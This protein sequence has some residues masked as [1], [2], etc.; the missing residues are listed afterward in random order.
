MFP[1]MEGTPVILVSEDQEKSLP[2]GITDQFH[3]VVVNSAEELGAVLQGGFDGW[4]A[5]RDRVLR[6]SER[7]G[8]ERACQ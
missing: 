5:Y 7:E 6:Q 3:A 1:V 2:D 8:E 4:R